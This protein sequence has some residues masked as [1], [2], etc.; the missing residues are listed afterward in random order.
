MYPVKMYLE[1]TK[2]NT[3]LQMC[4]KIEVL[5]C[6]WTDKT[7]RSIPNKRN[8]TSSNVQYT[9]IFCRM[10][11]DPVIELY[12]SAFWGEMFQCLTGGT[13]H[14]ICNKGI[15]QFGEYRENGSKPYILYS[16]ACI[17]ELFNDYV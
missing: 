17:L 1:I 9:S 7:Y 10:V 15:N 13:L 6:S 14:L 16:W 8:R 2:W 12:Y 11:F 5:G 3:K 4:N